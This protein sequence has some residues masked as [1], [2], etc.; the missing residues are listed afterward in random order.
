MADAF[1]EEMDRYRNRLIDME[2]E[3]RKDAKL[4]P[5]FLQPLV[6]EYR[7]LFNIWVE[8]IEDISKKQLRGGQIMDLIQRH[9]YT[10]LPEVKETYSRYVYQSISSKI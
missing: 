7:L 1:D 8:T 6:D 5:R 4:T 10:G 9:L 3:F 2:R